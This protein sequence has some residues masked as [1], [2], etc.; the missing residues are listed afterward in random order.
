MENYT[1][2]DTTVEKIMYFSSKLQELGDCM[3]DLMPMDPTDDIQLLLD[4]AISI[5]RITAAYSRSINQTMLDVRK[6]KN[7]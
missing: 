2:D 7:V 6:S 5:N 4:A 3:V 1:I